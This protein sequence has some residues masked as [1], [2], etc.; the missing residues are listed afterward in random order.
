MKRSLFNLATIISLILCIA[1]MGFWIRSYWVED[2]WWI[3]H[4]ESSIGPGRGRTLVSGSTYG[5]LAIA[6]ARPRPLDGRKPGFFFSHT[7]YSDPGYPHIN[8]MIA[9]GWELCGFLYSGGVTTGA[10]DG[11]VVVP[12]ALPVIIFGLLPMFW[13]L[14]LRKKRQIN[15]RR[16]NALCTR[17][18]YDIRATPARC[19]EC[20]HLQS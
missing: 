1:T 3:T 17:C 14:H 4:N 11:L 5:A 2:M 6:W 9:R 19:S 8:H 12:A 16:K 7:T 13:L 20:G 18:G 15:S 10:F